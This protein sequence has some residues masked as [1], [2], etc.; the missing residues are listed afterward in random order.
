MHKRDAQQGESLWK[1]DEPAVEAFLVS[2]GCFVFSGRRREGGEREETIVILKK[3]RFEPTT[4]YK[5]GLPRRGERTAGGGRAHDDGEHPAQ[6]LRVHH[7]TQG[8]AP[9]LGSKSWSS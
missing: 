9:L 2:S 7:P 5:R 8:L 4:V 3:Y 6:R 1:K